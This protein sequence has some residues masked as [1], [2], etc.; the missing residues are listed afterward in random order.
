MMTLL[1]REGLFHVACVVVWT[2][3][4]VYR[5]V[6]DT[7]PSNFACADFADARETDRGAQADKRK[8]PPCA[9]FVSAPFSV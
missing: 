5:P 4:F 6:I 1:I 7:Q 8:R 2:A 3:L 9:S